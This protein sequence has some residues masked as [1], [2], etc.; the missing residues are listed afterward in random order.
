MTVTACPA[1]V[2]WNHMLS[3]SGMIKRECMVGSVRKN[4]GLSYFFEI[5]LDLVIFY[6]HSAR[7]R[8]AEC[9]WHRM[10]GHH[11]ARMRVGE[12]REVL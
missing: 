2:G 7:L 11:T 4:Q 5:G 1:C 6:G 3:S 12:E 8:R 10:A 9:G